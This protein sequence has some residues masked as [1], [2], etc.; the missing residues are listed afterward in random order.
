MD[1]FIVRPG[2]WNLAPRGQ[3]PRERTRPRVLD[4][5]AL[6]AIDLCGKEGAAPT[7]NVA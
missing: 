3:P 5:G 6:A 7:L 1:S 2:K 4:C